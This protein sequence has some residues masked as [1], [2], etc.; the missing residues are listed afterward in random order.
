VTGQADYQAL[1]RGAVRRKR[2]F[3]IIK[4]CRRMGCSLGNGLLC[5]F[6]FNSKLK[7]QTY[8]QLFYTILDSKGTRGY[9]V[10]TL[11]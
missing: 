5:V 6:L 7:K 10:K 2:A 9:R 8:D 11:F 1:R 3:S 4:A